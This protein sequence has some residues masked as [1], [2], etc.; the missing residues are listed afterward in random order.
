[1]ASDRMPTA[2]LT[3]PRLRIF[4]SSPSDVDEE[5]SVAIA[6]IQRLQA[7]FRG[8]FTLVPILWEREP[9]LATAGFQHEIDR[10]AP[11][12]EA[13]I[14]V[15]ILW[16]R[17][18]TPLGR[19]FTLD[20]GS[21][22]TGT[23][24]EF[25]RARDAARERRTPHILV[26]RKT[27][28]P[29]T[30]ASL[31]KEVLLRQHEDWSAVQTFFERHFRHAEG[32]SFSGSFSPFAQASQFGQLLQEHLTKLLN[33]R[34]ATT[35]TASPTAVW[36]GSPF[37]GLETFEPE[38]ASIFFGRARAIQEALTGLR[39][40]RRE[41]R[42]FLAIV[43]SSGSGK[44]S[45][46]RAGL[47]PLLTYPGAIEP[48]VQAGFCRVAMLR[49]SD[50]PTPLEAL[51]AALRT[52]GALPGLSLQ[53]PATAL[54]TVFHE[55]P[56]AA[57][58]LVRGEL[59]RIGGDG[60][61]VVFVDQ[62]EELFTQASLTDEDRAAFAAVIDALARSGVVWVL[63]TLRGDTYGR[64]AALPQ[65]AALAEGAGQHLL[66]PP[67]AADLAQIVRL[68]AQVAGLVY[69]RDPVS[70]R[71]LDEIVHAEA[72][73]AG[74][75]ALPLLEYALSALY[76]RARGNVLT[77][78]AFE[79]LGGIEGAVRARAEA[80]W[81]ALSEAGRQAFP[82]VLRS[83]VEVHGGID[84]TVTRRPAPF[85]E[86]ARTP[87][88]KEFVERFVG[89]RLLVADGAGEAAV[90]RV[91][92]EALLRT[93][94][95]MA[96]QIRA[97]R[98]LLR[99]HGWLRSRTAHWEEQQRSRGALLA[100]PEDLTDAGRLLSSGFE[101]AD[102]ERA[103][104]E[105]SKARAAG[106]RRVRRLAV[107]VIGVLAAAGI[108][109]AV[110]AERR[111]AEATESRAASQRAQSRLLELSTF[112]MGEMRDRLFAIGRPDLLRT[113]TAKTL[114]MLETESSG[115]VEDL[116][117][118]AHAFQN[119]AA[120]RLTLG[121]HDASRDASRRALALIDQAISRSDD[122]S[123]DR[124]RRSVILHEWGQLEDAAG[125][126]EESIRLQRR[127]LADLDSLPPEMRSQPVVQRS[128]AMVHGAL[129]CA[130]RDDGDVPAALAEAERART[131]G[132]AGGATPGG[133]VGAQDY[134]RMD[135][136]VL[137]EYWWG[138]AQAAGGQKA[139]AVA[140]F[141]RGLSLLEPSERDYPRDALVL[142][143]GAGLRSHLYRAL[144]DMGRSA[145]G[146]RRLDES[147][148]ARRV[149]VEMFP[150]NARQRTELLV[151]MSMEAQHLRGAGRPADSLRAA[152]AFVDAAAEA[153]R[154]W[155]Q[156]PSMRA[157]G[158]IAQLERAGALESLGQLQDAMASFEAAS[159][160]FDGAGDA[161][162]ADPAFHERILIA[163]LD[164]ARV[165]GRLG[166]APKAL[167]AS[168]SALTE[169]TTRAKAAPGEFN[170]RRNLGMAQILRS[171]ALQ[172]AGRTEESLEI[173]Q[174]AVAQFAALAADWPSVVE[175]RRLHGVVLARRAQ[176]IRATK[177]ERR[178]L[179]DLE[180]SVRELEAAVTLRPGD[181][182]LARL[183]YVS[184]EQI[185]MV[186][187]QLGELDAA[188]AAFTSQRAA[189]DA[190]LPANPQWTE[191][192]M[193][194]RSSALNLG[195]VH[196]ALGRFADA[197]AAFAEAAALSDELAGTYQDCLQALGEI[198]RALTEVAAQQ[199][200]A[201]GRDPTTPTERVGAAYLA[202][203]RGD[204]R[205]SARLF[206]EG[207]TDPSLRADA[208][209]AHLYN[210]ACSAA[211]AAAKATGP[212]RARWIEAGLRWAEEHGTA[213]ARRAQ[214]LRAELRSTPPGPARNRRAWELVQHVQSVN[215]G[216]RGDSDLD[217]LRTEPR[218]V[219]LLAAASAGVTEGK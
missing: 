38:H 102:A 14:A 153:A 96:E 60:R 170:A 139:E 7:W 212:D 36:S 185:G 215:E 84:A 54:A 27:A 163:H 129:S 45:L 20:D 175:S 124:R 190:L 209:A 159:R 167:A 1:M 177:D 34:L 30:R 82:S 148:K 189:I 88:A 26:Y 196:R 115:T 64:L 9:L 16:S 164:L 193:D 157:H 165:A 83:L 90:V 49:P 132:Y 116:R 69:E 214:E 161:V 183:V 188:L 199:A 51:C 213:T 31:P 67:D 186:R 122:A 39:R 32:V 63:A 68:P 70:G 80:E 195:R 201:E 87:G 217:I 202:Y 208:L 151:C 13:D 58:G 103:F 182:E 89:A 104:V 147:L 25:V 73:K 8:R 171:D 134:W 117:A 33:E 55:S 93:W 118:R 137:G 42:A 211:L 56:A 97:E 92:H 179:P 3:P 173:L 149:L 99:L 75:D 200:A 81:G 5:R 78:A 192:R 166:D 77:V 91:A 206:E 76:D 187:E 98:R 158:A 66:A 44:S 2:D 65:L 133:T 106:A 72:A 178:A 71:T 43:G 17:L 18:G 160:A 59:A 4:L 172:Q 205:A 162:R 53:G 74:S 121:E 86:V 156:I 114:E 24:W 184:Q 6:V 111:R 169:A 181:P 29:P 105:A 126:T 125:R 100:G 180:A 191:L 135:Y 145:E 218:F 144:L 216:L 210:A 110:L 176:H 113:L 41:G 107:G 119:L 207:L 19:E 150:D 142:D 127:A 15:F 130:A 62:M 219:A 57:V 204:Y 194:R 35:A 22:P 21:R 203:R 52:E 23:E 120:A 109:M 12:S 155:P 123:E 79:A 141:E 146:D 95:R 112:S 168:E 140:S 152:D 198:R 131:A 197:T 37:R 40:T 10:R 50:A 138:A 11:P 94:G 46:V 48:E 85:H 47:L 143:A 154:Q 108:T 101:L 128:L 61:L 28:E 136:R 174:L